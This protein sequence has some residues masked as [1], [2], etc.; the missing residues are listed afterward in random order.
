MPS[1]EGVKD[2]WA[3][4]KCSEKGDLYDLLRALRDQGV[5][6]AAGGFLEHGKLLAKL[7]DDYRKGVVNSSSSGMVSPR[8]ARRVVNNRLPRTRSSDTDLAGVEP[9]YRRGEEKAAARAWSAMT[10]AQRQA[11]YDLLAVSVEHGTNLG[12]VVRHLARGRL[13]AW[14]QQQEEA[15]LRA[16]LAERDAQHVAECRCPDRCDDA[17]CRRARGLRPL[18]IQEIRAGLD[19]YDGHREG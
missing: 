18:T 12:A 5:P 3:C 11:L 16:Y 19:Q 14:R 17:P 6:E 8:V 2:R 10:P 7:E 15:A 9:G 13:S 1:L 4:H